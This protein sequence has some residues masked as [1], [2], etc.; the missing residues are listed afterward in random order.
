MS[1]F[2]CQH[3]ALMAIHSSRQWWMSTGRVRTTPPA[4]WHS[5]S[6]IRA[7]C[8]WLRRTLKHSSDAFGT[9]IG[10]QYLTGFDDLLPPPPIV[11]DLRLGRFVEQLGDGYTRG[12]SRR[13]V[14]QLDLD[15][16][17]APAR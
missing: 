11:I 10:P 15:D 12:A 16:R 8:P 7:A 13:P 6:L 2:P 1:R 3:V 4:P 9:A 17:A 14:L 5:R